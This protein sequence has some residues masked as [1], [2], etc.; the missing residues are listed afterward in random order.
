M[1]SVSVF[2]SIKSILFSNISE[3]KLMV[4]NAD[5]MV[6]AFGFGGVERGG[7][8]F[9]R[10]G[11]FWAVPGMAAALPSTDVENPSFVRGKEKCVSPFCAQMKEIGRE[12]VKMLCEGKIR[13]DD[14]W[15]NE[16]ERYRSKHCA[17]ALY[18]GVYVC[19]IESF[20]GAYIKK[21]PL[22]ENAPVDNRQIS[23]PE[24]KDKWFGVYPDGGYGE[25]IAFIMGLALD[26]ESLR[27]K[28]LNGLD[29]HIF[30]LNPGGPKPKSPVMIHQHAI[31]VEEMDI[32]GAE[33]ID[34][35]RRRM[36]KT[37]KFVDVKHVLDNSIIKECRGAIR[38]YCKIEVVE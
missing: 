2:G 6:Y 31:I 26:T 38:P 20:R 14:L 15:I 9:E 10:M 34:E 1:D 21:T 33:T 7:K 36:L 35:L 25:K 32:E 18:G 8:A 30:Y 28:D 5:D 11:E 29:Q 16:I 13:A 3:E 12:S 24:I 4:K 37:S 27:Q 23:D 19:K 22:R 17:Q